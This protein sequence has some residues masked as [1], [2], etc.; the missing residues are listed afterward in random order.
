MTDRHADHPP[1][2][3]GRVLS[4]ASSC[5]ADPTWSASRSSSVAPG[6]AGVIA[7]AS[8]EARRY[9]VCS[10]MPSS[11]A[12]RLCP[13][14]V[15]LPGDH[16][17]YA[18]VSADVHA[19]F[20]VVHTVRRTAGARRGVPRRHRRAAPARRPGSVIAQDDPRAGVGRAAAALLRRRGPEQVPRQAGIGGRQADCHARR[21]ARRAGRRRGAAGQRAGVPA[22]ASGA[23]AVG[24]RAGDA[25]AAAA[26]RGPHRRRSRRTR[27]G[28]A[29][30]LRRR[31]SRSA[32]V[33]A[34]W[35][36]R[37]PPGRGRPGDEVDR[38]RGDV[39]HR[40]AH[41]R[42]AASASSFAWP[43]VSHARLRA[44]PVRP[45]VDP[46]GPLRRLPDHHPIDHRGRAGA[47]QRTRSSPPSSRCCGQS[48]RP[49]GASARCQRV[50][51][52]RARRA[53]EPRRV[54]DRRGGFADGAP[55]DWPRRS[56]HRRDPRAVR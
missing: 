7:A 11:P 6:L 43:T 15:F 55:A 23:S 22:P 9:G 50:E 54:L 36:R 47:R 53:T 16:D 21:G 24:S 48:T 33:R 34:G 13:H 28:R 39:R 8:Y 17:L 44:A 40:P 25:G 12:R 41:P 29:R 37:R 35:A 4:S 2:R 26:A 51:L 19:I 14:A 1:R 32:P 20:T 31:G 42:R 10:A 45:H 30:R 18:S 56:G 49:R 3:H 52:R 27:R 46:E 5:V 38:P